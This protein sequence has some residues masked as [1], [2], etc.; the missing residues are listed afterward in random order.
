MP[1]MEWGATAWGFQT[2]HD[3]V[4][5]EWCILLY[6][7]YFLKWHLQ[8][9]YVAT[10]PLIVLFSVTMAALKYKEGM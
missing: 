9:T 8:Y 7:G 3:G 2:S 1:P 5:L 4:Y 6:V 10:M